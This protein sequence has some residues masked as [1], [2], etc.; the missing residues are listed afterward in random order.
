MKTLLIAL[1]LFTASVAE[2]TV[3]PLFPIS[4]AIPDLPLVTLLIVAA[5]AGP[6]SA[7]LGIPFVALCLG[8]GSDRSPG[9]MLIG[10]LPM[11]PIAAG[12]EESR[13]PLNQF[14]RVLVTGAAAGLWLRGLLATVAVLQGAGL[15]V[16][17]LIGGLL[18][19]G[20]LLDVALLAVAYLSLRLIGLDGHRVTL[21]RGGFSV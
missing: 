19:P 7:M 8:F 20:L 11:L 12:L 16:G 13:V 5:Y 18:V 3:A 21:Q 6:K 1:L 15:P 4:A 9:L 2:I 10:Y 14:S 17:T